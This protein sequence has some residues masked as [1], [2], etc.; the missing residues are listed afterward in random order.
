MALKYSN[1]GYVLASG[2]VAACGTCKKLLKDSKV[3]R[4]FLGGEVI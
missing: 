2:E 1:R 3:Q 4:A